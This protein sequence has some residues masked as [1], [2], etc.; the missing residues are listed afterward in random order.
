MAKKSKPGPKPKA[1]S[2]TDAPVISI[3]VPR[4]LLTRVDESAAAEG[5]KRAEW[6][7]GSMDMWSRLTPAQKAKM[8]GRPW[9]PPRN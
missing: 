5:L 3:K 8:C 4:A 1:D 7:R 6:V 9:P 2:L